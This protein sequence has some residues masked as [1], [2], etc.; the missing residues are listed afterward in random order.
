MTESR[1]IGDVP[2]WDNA[3]ELVDPMA[4]GGGTTVERIVSRGHTTDWY[5]QDH[6][7]W[8]M[9]HQGSARLELQDGSELLLGPGDHVILPAHC[10]HRVSWTDPEV[11]TIWV[12]VHFPA[13][14]A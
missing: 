10:A 1:N 13:A 8:V 9:V 4:S 3:A 14:R 6:D 2:A 5:D 11:D 12:A 7:E